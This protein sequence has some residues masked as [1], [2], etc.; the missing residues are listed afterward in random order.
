MKLFLTLKSI[1]INFPFDKCFFFFFRNKNLLNTTAV[2][3]HVQQTIFCRRISCFCQ[4][5]TIFDKSCQFFKIR[6]LKKQFFI[7]SMAYK[8]GINLC[9]PLASRSIWRTKW[10][11]YSKF[12]Q[13]V[14]QIFSESWLGG[15]GL[16]NMI[17]LSPW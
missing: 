3:I 13:N 4:I 8:P 11:V 14:L 5:L 17:R 15:W 1:H 9:R 12:V 6:S 7:I 2:T 10:A 16:G